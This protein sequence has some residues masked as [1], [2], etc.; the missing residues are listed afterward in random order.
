MALDKIWVVVDRSGDKAGAGLA[1]VAHQGAP[2]RR[3]RRGGHLGRRR[4]AGRRQRAPT[5]P[6]RCTRVG[7]LGQRPARAGRGG[8]HGRPDRG[9]QRSRRHPGAADLRRPRHRRPAVGRASTARC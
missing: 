5:A 2:G 8:R 7:D 3:H 6:P 1:R 9:G 4:P